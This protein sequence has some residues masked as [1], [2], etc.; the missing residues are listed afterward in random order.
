LQLKVLSVLKRLLFLTVCCG[1]AFSGAAQLGGQRSFEFLNVPANARLAALGGVN[2]SLADR[3]VNFF[4]SN[5]A[6][7]SDSLQGFGAAT[8]QFYVADIGQASFVYAHS[9]KRIG[10]LSFGV[11]H[12]SLGTIKSY[13]ATGFELGEFKSGETALVISKSHQVS[14]FRLGANL[15]AVFS[16]VAGYRASA[17]MLDLG[18][19]FVHPEQNLTIGIVLKNMGFL[20]SDYSETSATTLPFDVQVGATYKPEHM[21]IRFSATAYNLTRTDLPYDDPSDDEE[22]GTLNKVL[23]RFNLGI[24]ILFH[25]NVNVMVGYNYNTHQELKLT[26]GGAGA[27]ISFGFSARI[28]SVEFVFSRGG[29]VAGAAG[30]TFTLA[31]N[32]N[33]L[34]RR[35]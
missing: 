10:T 30:Y 34:I 24:E 7:V 16:N 15:K 29:Y 23:R 11:Q 22:A 20:L 1:V 21:P 28:K 19:T 4:Y 35:R 13:D 33:R 6:L 3:D 26:N 32:V 18:G 27:G 2:A 5:P 12:L 31:S 9:F 25:R 17:L 14:A 8:W